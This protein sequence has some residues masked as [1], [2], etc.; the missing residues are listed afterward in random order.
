MAAQ[1]DL[2]MIWARSSATPP[3]RCSGTKGNRCSIGWTGSSWST[4]SRRQ[5]ASCSSSGPSWRKAALAVPVGGAWKR[6]PFVEL[7][8]LALR[9]VLDGANRDELLDQLA[10]GL[11]RAGI[12]RLSLSPLGKDDPL[13]DALKRRG[14]I[15]RLR[16]AASIGEFELGE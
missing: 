1:V 12:G 7:V 10:I 11:R 13:A 8:L 16:K 5:R 15:T 3:E 9:P 2:L 6:H 4:S 14:W